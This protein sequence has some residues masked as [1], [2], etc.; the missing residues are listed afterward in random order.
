M[1]WALVALAG[2]AEPEVSWV[3]LAQGTAR[4]ELR[5][6][7]TQPLPDW[8]QQRCR[9]EVVLSEERLSLS[10]HPTAGSSPSPCSPGFLGAAEAQAATWD[11]A[12]RSYRPRPSYRLPVLLVT[13]D[14]GALHLELFPE[15]YAVGQDHPAAV[16]LVEPARRLPQRKRLPRLGPDQAAALAEGASATCSV[17]LQVRPSGRVHT[18]LAHE[19]CDARLRARAESLAAGMRFTPH[20]VNGEAVARALT[21]SVRMRP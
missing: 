7:A 3:A 9:A 19:D 6:V 20:L 17:D 21:V 11:I 18:T 1:W 15:G 4:A 13:A 10:P 12:V 16:H 8:P 2:A 14:D 5:S